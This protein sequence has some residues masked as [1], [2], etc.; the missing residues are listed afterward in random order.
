MIKS[1]Y[2]L[3]TYEVTTAAEIAAKVFPK[4]SLVTAIDTGVIKKG[5][6]ITAFSALP[7]FGTTVTKAAAQADSVA[8]TV[9]AT[10]IDF[11]SLLAKLRAAG[12]MLP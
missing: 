2:N 8:A 6:G 12:L 11:N 7:A 4:N 10:V 9:A 5:D 1:T 3:Q